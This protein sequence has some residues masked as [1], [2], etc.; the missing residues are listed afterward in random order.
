MRVSAGLAT[1]EVEEN[2]G[3]A[4]IGGLGRLAG[5]AVGVVLA[6]R[7]AL[8]L[9][10]GGAVGAGVDRRAR[11]GPRFAQS[12][13]VDG[14][15]Q[16]G[17]GGAGFGHPIFQRDILV[18]VARHDHPIAPRRLQ[19]VAQHFGEG[20]DQ[21]LLHRAV[22]AIGAAVDAAVTGIEHDDR[23]ALGER[24]RRRG[25][26]RGG[27]RRLVIERRGGEGGLRTGAQEKR[28]PRRRLA[29]HQTPRLDAG[30][31][32]RPRQV[33]HHARLAGPEQAEA[34]RLYQRVGVAR[35][36][37]AGFRLEAEIDL[38]HVEHDAVGIGDFA[39][40]GGQ[41]GRE[42]EGQA[43]A[44]AIVG[45]MDGGRHRRRLAGAG[46]GGAEDDERRPHGP[47]MEKARHSG[48][49]CGL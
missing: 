3:D 5:L 2:V 34:E 9:G 10:V 31:A 7:D 29:T 33:D 24:R 23:Q 49:R 27:R 16:R 18:A 8:R 44:G 6:L 20:E 25:G 45:E 43:R 39:R 42:I 15:E 35:H 38:G 13:G 48:S 12:V 46:R 17:V 37:P 32:G 36:R 19:L 1:L 11:N 41:W 14:D 30:D 47:K 22:E 28:Q 21:R 26:R 40:A 4:G